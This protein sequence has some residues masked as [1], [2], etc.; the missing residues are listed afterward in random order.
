MLKMLRQ[1]DA[2]VKPASLTLLQQPVAL[3]ALR[4]RH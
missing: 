4:W 2:G 3:L 1:K